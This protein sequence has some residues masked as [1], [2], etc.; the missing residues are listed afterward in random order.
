[1]VWKYPKYIYNSIKTL[2]HL[3]L[4]KNTNFMESLVKIYIGVCI[5]NPFE[6]IFTTITMCV[7]LYLL[8]S[9]ITSSSQSI[10]KK[11]QTL[12]DAYEQVSQIY[13]STNKNKSS[14]KAENRLFSVMPMH[15][16]SFRCQRNFSSTRSFKWE[17]MNLSSDTIHSDWKHSCYTTVTIIY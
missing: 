7:S 4:S 17:T 11:I 14:W 12:T 3:Y 6:I 1:M 13:F 2:T 10:P 15:S 8:P 9:L 5:N 16:C